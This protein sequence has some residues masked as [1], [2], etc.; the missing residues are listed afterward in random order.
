MGW[1]IGLDVHKDT[2]A[3]AALNPAGGLVAEATF[4]N[5]EGGHVELL[6]WSVANTADVRCGLEPSPSASP[7]AIRAAARAE[8]VA[9]GADAI[10]A[11]CCD[12]LVAAIL[13]T[14]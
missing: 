10:V 12:D 8:L 3:A 11:T 5:T 1:V 14:G 2:I 6:G 7:R 9:A 13:R 4:D